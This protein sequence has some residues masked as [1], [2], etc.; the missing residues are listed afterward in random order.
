[1][2]VPYRGR[3]FVP[4]ICF[5]VVQR[6]ARRRSFRSNLGTVDFGYRMLDFHY[7]EATPMSTIA[8][9]MLGVLVSVITFVAALLVGLDEAA[10][11]VHSRQEDL[12]KLE[13]KLVGRPDQVHTR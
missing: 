5:L 1:M 3:N 2:A 4:P 11:Q 8:I 6:S 7:S 12:T 9:F 10:D 13:K